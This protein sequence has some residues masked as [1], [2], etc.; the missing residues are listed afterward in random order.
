MRFVHRANTS[1]INVLTFLTPLKNQH[2]EKPT[3]YHKIKPHDGGRK[4]G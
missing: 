3:N 1:K 4:K 2:H